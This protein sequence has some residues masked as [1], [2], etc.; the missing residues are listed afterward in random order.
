MVAVCGLLLTAC[1]T[2]NSAKKGE[3]IINSGTNV[4]IGLYAGEFVID[5]E[6]KGITDV[7]ATISAT[8]DW[9]RIKSNVG[10]KAT[11]QYEENTSGGTRQ[12]A[13]MLSSTWP[14]FLPKAL[15]NV[16]RILRLKGMVV[17]AAAI[18]KEASVKNTMGSA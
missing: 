13:I 3:I 18:P 9:L 15:S 12:A 14:T 16:R 6:I 8:S 2:E 7:D 17:K 4:E 10:G 1:E 5:Y 11:I